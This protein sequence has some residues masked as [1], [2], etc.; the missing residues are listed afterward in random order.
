MASLPICAL[1][2]AAFLT[3]ESEK[4]TFG[5]PTVICSPHDFKDLLPHKSMTLH[6]S[7]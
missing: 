2:A 7:N 5:A 4:L 1:A 3:Q 6:A